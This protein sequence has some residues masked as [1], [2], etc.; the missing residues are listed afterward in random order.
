M[1]NVSIKVVFLC[2]FSFISTSVYPFVFY[3]LLKNKEGHTILMLG[4]IHYQKQLESFDDKHVE[5]LIKAALINKS[6]VLPCIIE[7]EKERFILFSTQGIPSDINLGDTFRKVIELY[8][9]HKED[10][11][12]KMNFIPADS[13]DKES[14]RITELCII[15]EIILKGDVP[16]PSLEAWEKIKERI[17]TKTTGVTLSSYFENLEKNLIKLQHLRDSYQANTTAYT[18][19][20]SFVTR[21][22]QAKT[23]LASYFTAITHESIVETAFLSLFDS[24]RTL[25][26]FDKK[27]AEIST[28]FNENL[29]WLYADAFFLHTLLTECSKEPHKALIIAGGAHILA[30]LPILKK[31]GYILIEEK[32]AIIDLGNSKQAASASKMKALTQDLQTTL[33]KYILEETETHCNQCLK[34]GKLFKC[35]RCKAIHYCSKEC[36]KTDWQNH[37]NQCK[38]LSP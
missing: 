35:G 3:Y 12:D 17:A 15:I 26:D 2:L 21:F 24:C 25:S 16:F 11:T 36:Q 14:D 29:Y 27:Y 5:L 18:I 30:L 1:N 6:K 28:A 31:L 32:N 38:P 10:L 13:R 20:E 9:N 37:K 22:S 4:D 19:F 33:Q 23:T 34:I 7:L 8:R